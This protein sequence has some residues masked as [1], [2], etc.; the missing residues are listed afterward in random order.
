MNP[1]I[2]EA[3]NPAIREAVDVVVRFLQ[4]WHQ[5]HRVLTEEEWGDF[6]TAVQRLDGLLR[7]AGG[8]QQ[9]EIPRHLARDHSRFSAAERKLLVNLGLEEGA[10]RAVA[11]LVASANAQMDKGRRIRVLRT[12]GHA[13]SL[14]NLAYAVSYEQ[15]PFTEISELAGK[16]LAGLRTT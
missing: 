9:I 7:D 11:Q 15:T 8:V 10:A 14:L 4:L 2:R 16:F 3:V 13:A 6:A 1:A 12:I 5:R